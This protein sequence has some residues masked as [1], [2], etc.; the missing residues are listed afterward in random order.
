[1]S[2]VSH[3]TE[4]TQHQG[5][6]D[7]AIPESLM[8]SRVPKAI[9]SMNR[10]ISI[11]SQSGNASQSGQ[12]VFQ[13][14]GG[15]NANGYLRAGS[16]YLRF[17]CT[18]NK[19]VAGGDADNTLFFANQTKSA[20][21][22]INRLQI[23]AN[24]TQIETIN[25]YDNWHAIV[26]AQGCN[27]GYV[28]NDSSIA[29]YAE[30]EETVST[31]TGVVATYNVS[32][33]LF[34]GVLS[35]SK[36]FPLFLSG[37]MLQVDLNSAGL[38]FKSAGTSPTFGVTYVISQAELVYECINPD[39]ALL[40]GMRGAMAQ[41]GRLFEMPLSTPLGLTTAIAT[42]QVS[43]SYNIGLNLASVSGV[44]MAEVA[45][46]VESANTAVNSFIRNSTE[47]TTNSRRMYLD[48]KQ[49]VNYDVWADSQ[50]F[51]ECQRALGTLLNLENTTIATRANYCAAAV[52]GGKFYVVG[53]SSKRFSESDLCMSG[54][55][56][57]NL[58]IQIAKS[59][60]PVATSVYLYVL[61]DAVCVIDANG[62]V[63]VAK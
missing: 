34:S 54:S 53:Q 57:S 29:E 9:P 12:I 15:S 63:A 24:G 45:Q 3:K 62:S 47:A 8:S 33:P 20:S 17:I 41:S 1:M 18:V 35:N 19:S 52:G 10:I 25:R 46:S 61:Y 14:P 7:N 51:L 6:S 16:A 55:P 44:F 60:S 59:G 50:N 26:Q 48:G 31:N 40:D 30:S 37:L 56:C 5:A 22:L 11:P 58:V 39:Y 38:S 21:S 36:S 28:N 42:D 13:V 27:A 43:F 49:I 32:L 2:F 23:S 4:P